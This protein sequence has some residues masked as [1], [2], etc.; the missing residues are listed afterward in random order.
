MTLD[1]LTAYV[2]AFV[3]ELSESGV[4]DVVISPGSR[5]T[6]LALMFTQHP[7]IKGL[8]SVDERSAAFFAL[9]IAKVKEKPVA[10]V[11]TS[12][13]AAANYYPAIIEAA[14]SH[15][16]LLV[17][18]A[19]R[20]HELRD[21]GAPQ[22]IDQI[23][24]YGKY[25]KW[26]H[27]MALPEMDDRILQYVRSNA[28]RAYAVSMDA[29]K[30]PVQLNFPF[31]EPLIPNYN[32]PDAFTYGK[33]T[34]QGA[35]RSFFSGKRELSEQLITELK[36]KLETVEKGVIVCGPGTYNH[37][38]EPIIDLAEKYQLPIFADPLSPLRKGEHNKDLV[39]EHYDALLKTDVI[40]D[41]K[42]ELVIRFGAMPVSKAYTQYV[43]KHS[44][45][46][47]WIIDEGEDWRDPTHS[48]GRMIFTD[49]KKFAEGL[50][51]NAH[52]LGSETS[53]TNN[54]MKA[55]E[56]AQYEKDKFVEI[57]DLFEGK[58]F[59]QIE[60]LI[61]NDTAL[62]VGNSMPIRDLDSFFGKTSKSIQFIANRGANGIDGVISSALGVASSGRKTVLVIGDL[63]FYHDMN[64]LLAAKMYELDITIVLVNNSGGGIFSFLPQA[65]HPEH[66][67]Q[68]FGTPID[69]SF[70]KATNLYDGQYHLV[71]SWLGFAEVFA[72]CID[73][74]GLKVIE[75]QTNREEN[76]HLHKQYWGNINTAIE[77][78]L[79]KLSDD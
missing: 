12:G 34:N 29:K 14:I 50:T 15:V 69:I 56:I 55:N 67:E 22:A 57:D 38:V 77:S 79:G 62:F 8:L 28:N 63:S 37:G 24:L 18:T 46:E 74:K 11:C 35:Y 75:L 2:G 64:G 45:C 21:V 76:V 41:W 59:S 17:L 30:G 52:K 3:D 44:D 39:I 53:W 1:P 71:Q 25:V 61:P 40:R 47:F 73:E 58:I 36:D 9:G 13:T 60:N 33:K 48:Q 31:R 66:F 51:V 5:S 7:K 72:K 20:P 49:T 43:Q 10:L 70:E 4:E 65:K 32:A 16:P 19:D 54:W 6:P 78:Q 27:E 42:P 26:F 68:L 23:G